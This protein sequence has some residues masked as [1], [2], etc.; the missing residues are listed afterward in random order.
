MS[1][2]DEV[3]EKGFVETHRFDSEAVE[4]ERG[5]WLFSAGINVKTTQMCYKP[6]QRLLAFLKKKPHT[7]EEILKSSSTEYTREDFPVIEQLQREKRLR[8]T[9]RAA[10]WC[11]IEILAP[12]TFMEKVFLNILHRSKYRYVSA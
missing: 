11:K 7:R 8:I 5:G 2:L 3:I 4:L 6:G 10:L 9:D 1:L 12:K